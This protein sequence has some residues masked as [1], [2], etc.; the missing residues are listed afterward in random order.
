[1]EIETGGLESLTGRN[2]RRQLI[3]TGIYSSEQQ[4]DLTH[5]VTYSSDPPGIVSIDAEGLVTPLKNGT[6]RITA[7]NRDGKSVTIELTTRRC[8]EDLRVSFDDEVVPLF[9]KLGCN[10]G[11]CHGKAD[12]QNGF[13]LSLLGFYPKD[14]YEYL[15]YEDRGRR[16]FPADPEYSL[17]L[18]KPANI[19]PHGGGK[20]MT[21]GSYEWQ[22]VTRW[23][24]Q[25]MPESRE[26]DP[27]LDHIQV[28]PAVRRMNFRSM[29]QLSVLAHYSD[30]SVRDVTRLASYEANRGEMATANSTGRVTVEDVP[31]E[32]A[33]MVRFQ[34]NVDVFRAVIPQGLP[35]KETPP[36]KSFVD[37]LVFNKLKTLG[38]PPSGLCDDA[39]FLRRAT[40]D[41]TGRL[42]TPAEVDGFLADA[43]ADKRERLVDQLVDS[44][45]Y[46][47]YFANKWS[48]VLRNR[49]RNNNDIPYTYRFHAWIRTSLRE[50]V[51][52]DQFVRGVLTATGEAGMHPPVAWFR[53]VR[54]PDQQMED[55]AQLFLGMRLACA[56]CHHHPFERWSQQ[57][58]YGFQA[59]FSQ[60]ALKSSKYNP[61]QNQPDMVYLNGRR[62]TARNPRTG[63]DVQ[64]AGLGA[65]PLDVPAYED[66]RQYLV[67][68][69]AAPENPFFARAL[70]NRYWKHFL[71]RGLIE[72]EDDIRDT[73]P[74]TNPE[75][76]AALEQHFVQSGFNLKELVR[77]ITQ[78]AT[79][80]LSS[81]PNE[82][83]VADEQNYSRY[84]PRRLQ[85]EVML[86]AIDDLTR[87][88]T[89][90]A[91]LPPGTRA[92]ALPDN[93]YNRASPFLK[94][95]GRP[96]NESVCECERVQSSSLAQ[97]L[98]LMNAGD[99]RTKLGSG[100]AD[101][102]AKSDAPPED[103]VRELYMAAF[104]RRPTDYELRVAVEF[105]AEP[106]LD[107]EGKS[108]DPAR[109]ARESF[110]DLLWALINTKEFLFNH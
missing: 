94:T 97:S 93:S 15:V 37:T 106:R 78:S 89:D 20:R 88:R 38:I 63:L 24:E 34:G 22:L 60:V 8:E 28:V 17:L 107:A 11:G 86:D 96:E 54:T 72:P 10:T 14:D 57:D 90:F 95:F 87:N 49:R 44:P 98:H 61:Q 36:E 50:N 39:T 59:F 55:V 53:E 71:R 103:K 100:R 4:H 31:G 43:S 32:V 70:V 7:R 80:Q 99:V 46:A 105:L 6:A 45:G 42:P 2:A 27:R 68:W 40:I 83:N 16:L 21:P 23:I 5:D 29:Q 76:L 82:Y 51:P 104:S 56:K 62:P 69:M 12:G 74:P 33:V 91:N 13:K 1:M 66:A 64:P 47:D 25:G 19:L 58:Y 35:V 102:L 9:T 30:G 92:I 26:E 109:A 77:V 3:V 108:V 75:L 65:E 101:Q 41:I 84:Y 67:D 18:Q 79:Y 48:A 52:Y 110:Q 85:A 73:N 81:V